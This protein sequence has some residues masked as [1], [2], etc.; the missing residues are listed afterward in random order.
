MT[1]GARYGRLRVVQVLPPEGERYDRFKVRCMCDCGQT[2]HPLAERLTSGRVKSCGC[3]RAE[4][5][6]RDAA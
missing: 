5:A 4:L 3:L 2:S 6:E 1:P